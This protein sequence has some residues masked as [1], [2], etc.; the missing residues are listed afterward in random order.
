MSVA[1]EYF[2]TAHAMIPRNQ[3]IPKTELPLGA[4]NRK[5]YTRYI[6]AQMKK[7]KIGG[8][9][10]YAVVISAK[11]DARSTK[12]HFLKRRILDSLMAWPHNSFDIVVVPL[13]AFKNL[14]ANRIK[15][16]ID[17]LRDKIIQYL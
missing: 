11:I 5:V 7:N 8:P 14:A 3:R 1:G 9:N 12:R 6:T 13:P 15:E 17:A 10:R 4:P 16:E 2:K